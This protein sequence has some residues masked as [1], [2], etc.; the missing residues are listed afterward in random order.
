VGRQKRDHQPR[1]DESGW[2]NHPEGNVSRLFVI[3]RNIPYSVLREVAD[4]HHERLR[5]QWYHEAPDD[6]T[7]DDLS[8]FLLNGTG[9]VVPACLSLNSMYL[10]PL[11][12]SAA[13]LTVNLPA[14]GCADFEALLEEAVVE[15]CKREYRLPRDYVRPMYHN[16][17]VTVSHRHYGAFVG[18]RGE[19]INRACNGRGRL[20][21]STTEGHALR[22]EFTLWVPNRDSI[23]LRDQIYDAYKD[24]ID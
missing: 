6:A 21:W 2:G 5:D 13:E 14:R 17:P 7:A 11:S 9:A 8:R 10:K 16:R 23:G 18:P 4:R 3:P 22:G 1:H 15:H 24:V 19:R 20:L 12:Q